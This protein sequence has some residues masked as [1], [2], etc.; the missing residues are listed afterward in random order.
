M[1]RERMQ[2]ELVAD[3]GRD[4]CGRR[5][6]DALDPR[7]RLPLGPGRGDVAA[8]GPDHRRGRDRASATDAARDE[9]LREARVVLRPRHRGARSAPRR[10]GR[11]PSGRERAMTDRPAGPGP[12]RWSPATERRLRV[13]APDRRRRP[14]PR[15]L[16]VPRQRRRSLGLPAA[17]P[18]GDRRA[19]RR[20]SDPRSGRPPLVT[21]HERSDRPR[22]R[23]DPRDPARRARGALARRSTGC[24]LPIVAAL[25]V[26]PIV[27]L[28][29]GAQLDVRRRQPVRPPGDR[30]AR[31]RSSPCSSTRSAACGRPVPCTAT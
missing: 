5:V 14:R 29:P 23:H 6:R 3:R 11:P 7:G 24:R 16:A 1:T 15:A 27:A 17:E 19:V 30:R 10:A 28:A 31:R 25:A 22:R 4:R 26:V 21:G 18:R 8:A 2:T 12:R 9:S 13:I 20:S